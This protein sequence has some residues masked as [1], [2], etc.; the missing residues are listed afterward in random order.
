[1]S[2]IHENTDFPLGRGRGQILEKST[3]PLHHHR[4]T[5][6]AILQNIAARFNPAPQN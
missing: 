5:R 1:M 4:R 6:A 2:K 3:F